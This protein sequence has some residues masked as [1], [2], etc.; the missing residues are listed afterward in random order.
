M[1][2]QRKQLWLEREGTVLVVVDVQERMIPAMPP[3]ILT[4]TTRNIRILLDAAAILK[5]PVITT[6]QYPAGLGHTIPELAPAANGELV[7]KTTF[8]CC[9]EAGFLEAL[10][11]LDARQVLLVGMESHVCVFQTLLDLLGHDYPVHLVRDA[12]CSQNKTDY[13]TALHNASLAGATVTTVQMA[14]FQM[15][16]HSRSPEFKAISALIKKR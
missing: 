7:E 11:R 6:E 3:E 9:G 8:S 2:D 1:T 10:K 14:L 4:K 13:M 12:V 16:R 15:L 5:L